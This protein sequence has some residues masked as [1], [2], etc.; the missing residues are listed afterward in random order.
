M[1]VYSRGGPQ[2]VPAPRPSL[3]YCASD[4][5]LS[6]EILTERKA[7]GEFRKVNLETEVNSLL[8]QRSVVSEMTLQT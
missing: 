4:Y 1:Y 8:N 2:T 6:N 7:N 3:I 5:D